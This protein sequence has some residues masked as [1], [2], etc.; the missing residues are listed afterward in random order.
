VDTLIQETQAASGATVL[1]V[2]HDTDLLW[3]VCHRVAVL[4][5]GRVL[6]LGTMAELANNPH[7][8]VAA[9]FMPRPGSA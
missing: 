8:T 7:P 6:A 9:Y 2:S 5:E 1:I 3:R 4:G